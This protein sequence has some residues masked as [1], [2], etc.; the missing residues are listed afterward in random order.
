VA[1]QS[2]FTS[3]A[4]FFLTVSA[5]LASGQTA[6][7]RAVSA[8]VASPAPPAIVIGFVGGFVGHESNIHGGVQLADHLRAEYPSGVHVGVFENHRGEAAHQE[9]LQLLDTNHDGALSSEEKH[10]ARIIIYGHS[11]GGSET[12]NLARELQ[13]DGIPVLLT[14]QIDSV[15][16]PGEDDAV[17]PANVVQA[18]NLYQS[19]GLVHG[20]T[21]IRAADPA[22]TQIIGNFKF[23]YTQHPISC[24]GYPWYARLFERSHIEIECDPVVS[25]QVEV[26]VR[27]KL[28]PAFVSPESR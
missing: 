26:L 20:R 15:R 28:P 27:S 12:V 22:H 17:I 7:E 5:V 16:K 9:I 21:L 13:K 2:A 11:W 3:I 10:N 6:S 14:I 1:V 19:S 8:P 18:A 24:A 25:D 23:D 4:V